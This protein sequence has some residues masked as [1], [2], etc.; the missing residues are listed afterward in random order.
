[1]RTQ[2]WPAVVLWCAAL[3]GSGCHPFEREFDV[4]GGPTVSMG[5]LSDDRY[6]LVRAVDVLVFDGDQLPC[7]TLLASRLDDPTLRSRA[8]ATQA[9]GQVSPER[10]RLCNSSTQD[11]HRQVL[12]RV[13]EG[14]KS[15]LVVAA[16]LTGDCRVSSDMG[17]PEVTT[18]GHVLAAGCEPMEVKGGKFHP[19]NV[20]MLPFRDPEPQ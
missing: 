19:V 6:A 4:T 7:A 17:G 8:A 14:K 18:P 9:S 20:V 16:Y 3:A 13:T 5:L 10:V 12:G 2:P 15:V 11:G 1:M